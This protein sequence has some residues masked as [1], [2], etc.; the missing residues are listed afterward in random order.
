MRKKSGILACSLVAMLAATKAFADGITIDEG[1]GIGLV[2]QQFCESVLR[3]APP[4][5]PEPTSSEHSNIPPAVVGVGEG[6]YPTVHRVIYNENLIRILKANYGNEFDV[7]RFLPTLLMMISNEAKSNP[8][9]RT[10]DSPKSTDLIFPGDLIFLPSSAALK[11]EYINSIKNGESKPQELPVTSVSN[12]P[13]LPVLDLPPD[14]F[15]IKGSGSV[16]PLTRRV[17]Q[18]FVYLGFTDNLTGGGKKYSRFQGSITIEE[19]S[20]YE[21]V[22]QFCLKGS[23][24]INASDDIEDNGIIRDSKMRALCEASG[25]KK[26]LKMTVATE[27]IWIIVNKQNPI[28]DYLEKNGLTLLQVSRLLSGN[29]NDWSEFLSA[30]GSEQPNSPDQGKAVKGTPALHFPSSGSGTLARLENL[31]HLNPK[32][33]ADGTQGTHLPTD[34]YQKIA[35]QVAAGPNE[36]GILPQTV[37]DIASAAAHDRGEPPPPWLTQITPIKIDNERWDSPPPTGAEPGYPL[38]RDL[39]L[40]FSEESLHRREIWAFLRFYAQFGNQ[41]TRHV[42]LFPVSPMNNVNLLNERR[43]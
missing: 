23:Q 42:G 21:G 4:T 37:F 3:S 13:P 10:F 40:Y 30:R 11:D 9:L 15:W 1:H 19:T 25:I 8:Q 36:V 2:D 28:G 6:S 27:N 35:Q 14:S 22:R 5:R 26:L 43:P 34:D 38:A 39:Y 24:I 31:L 29:V 7:N 33:L 18:C 20:T 16:Y 17:G 32:A 41:L 12:L